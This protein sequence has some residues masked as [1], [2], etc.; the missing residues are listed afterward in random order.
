LNKYQKK[1]LTAD[2]TSDNTD[3][4]DLR[5][6][7]LTIGKVYKV[8]ALP[9]IQTNGSGHNVNFNIE[10]DGSEVATATVI[11]DTNGNHTFDIA[12]IITATASTVTFSCDSV[13]TGDAI[14]G[15]DT[16]SETF[17]MIEELNNYQE[18]SSF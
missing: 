11:N 4:A 10:H 5:F 12:A 3:I 14:Q 17:V 16:F 1:K 13:A 7:N 2:V 6:E 15:N 8:T 9:R 18:V